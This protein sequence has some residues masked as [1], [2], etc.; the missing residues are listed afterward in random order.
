MSQAA[1]EEILRRIRVATAKEAAPPASPRLYRPAMGAGSIELFMERLCDYRAVVH[2]VTQDDLS[3]TVSECFDRR[4]VSRVVA[5]AGVPGDWLRGTSAEVLTDAPQLSLLELD[6]VDGVITSCSVAIAETGTIVLTHGAGQGRRAATLIPDYHLVV[7]FE[8]QVVVGV[9]DAVAMLDATQPMTWIS[10][11][12]A[13]SDIEL[14]RVEGVH[15]PRA[16]EVLVVG[17]RVATIS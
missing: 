15:G 1:R 6:G 7:V 2:R 17:G 5:P 8:D 9:P 12:S 16:L 4:R 14:R 3:G 10:G 13:T 11:P